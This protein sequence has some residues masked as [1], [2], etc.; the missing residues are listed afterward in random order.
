MAQYPVQDYIPVRAGKKYFGK[1]EELEYCLFFNM[2]GLWN[3]MLKW[4]FEEP[5]RSACEMECMI[6]RSL[7]NL[8]AADEK[9]SDTRSEVK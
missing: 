4:L 9:T 7:Q 3:I 1:K 5:E 8:L 6:R 2:G